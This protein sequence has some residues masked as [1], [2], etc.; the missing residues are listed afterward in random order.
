MGRLRAACL[1]LGRCSWLYREQL[2][3]R[4]A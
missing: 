4:G 1:L 2:A 3:P